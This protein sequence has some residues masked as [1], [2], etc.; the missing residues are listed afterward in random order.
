ML[1]EILAERRFQTED[2]N[3]F[4]CLSGDFNPMHMDLFFARRTQP[5]APVVHGMHA[6][7]WAM[8]AVATAGVDLTRLSQAKVQF[9][10]F[11]Y[12]DRQVSLRFVKRDDTQLRLV[13]ERDGLTLTTLNLRFDERKAVPANVPGANAVPTSFA[14]GPL[15]PVQADMTGLSGWLAS[16]ADD[17]QF[18]ALFPALEKAIG[19]HRISAIAQLSTLVGMACPG[20]HSIF[21]A[22][23]V[24]LVDGLETGPGLGWQTTQVDNRFRMVSMEFA[25]SGLM[26][27]VTAFIRQ[28][29]VPPPSVVSLTSQVG[30]EEFTGI[31]ALIIGGSRGLGAATA[32]LLAA[33]GAKL[34]ITY[35]HCKA[36]AEA[37]QEDINSAR[38][39][40]ACRILRFDATGDASSQFAGQGG[41]DQMYYFATTHIFQQKA[42]LYSPALFAEFSRIYVDGFHAALRATQ[43]LDAERKLAA[44]YPSSVA[45]T[46]RPPG[47]TEYAM[48]K[49]AG[50]ALCADLA[51]FDQRLKLVVHRIPR[52]LTDQTA[53]ASEVAASDPVDVMLPQIR[54]MASA[55]KGELPG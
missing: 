37:L 22:F 33:G 15:T 30:A 27:D 20:L 32:K 17:T 14:N 29:P 26:G 5:G 24:Q 46:E 49:A 53:T 38:G 34:V 6:F 41:F 12:L 2:Q 52:T 42:E 23:T 48:A 36:E 18:A 19:A 3:T 16:P 45:L 1:V 55:T 40:N 50:E 35:L 54:K 47:M 43:S 31:S 21:S 39:T 51:Q 44:F 10:R 25:G 7:L 4:A 13:I 8:D 28:E 9:N 11:I